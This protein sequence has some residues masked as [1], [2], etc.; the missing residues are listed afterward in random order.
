ME[1]PDKRG[2]AQEREQMCHSDGRMLTEQ[3]EWWPLDNIMTQ[4]YFG[5]ERARL[6]M[7][8]CY[9]SKSEHQT[10]SG[11]HFQCLLPFGASAFIIMPFLF[12]GPA[13]QCI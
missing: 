8:V 5:Y 12:M 10:E 2:T 3:T 6:L 7:S 13:L 11:C 1:R 9:I 4:M